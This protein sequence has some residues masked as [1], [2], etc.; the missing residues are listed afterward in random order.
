MLGKYTLIGEIAR[1]G[2][3]IVYLAQAQGPGGFKKSVIIKELKSELSDDENFREMFLEEANLAARLN[4]RNIV[5]TNEVGQD[6]GRYFM[7]MDYLEGCSLHVARKRLQGDDKLGVSLQL[8]VVSEVLAGLHYAHELTDY[9]G[10]PMGVVHRDV[11]P[12]NVFLTYDGQVKL[13]D[14]GVAKVLNRQLETQAGV[15]KGRVAYMAPEQVGG[16]AV[17]RRVDVFAAGVLLREILTNQRLWA[18]LGEID[19]LKKLIGRDIPLFPADADVPEELREICVKAMAPDPNDRFKTAHAMRVQLEQYVLRADPTGSLA[20]LGTHLAKGFETE[21]KRMKD[22]LDGH[23]GSDGSVPNIGLL[24]PG[25]SPD[26]S[27]ASA[28]GSGA[29]SGS[30]ARPAASSNRSAR[31][32]ASGTLVSGDVADID[33]EFDASPAT[34]TAAKRKRAMMIAGAVA[35]IALAAVVV[36]RRGDAGA[37]T[38]ADRAAASSGVA[39]SSPLAIPSAQGAASAN[40]DDTVEVTVRVTP[41]NAQIFL[42]EAPVEGNPFRARFPRNASA[43]HAVRAVANGFVAKTELVKFEANASLSMSLERQPVGFVPGPPVA[44]ADVRASASAQPTTSTPA[45][46]AALVPSSKP[47]STEI[48]ARGGKPPKRDIDP[49]NPY[50]AE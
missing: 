49:K 33:V 12:Q 14:F 11:G 5:Q 45:Q 34:D 16:G 9:D 17:D 39:P 28:P 7:A 30:G 18:G 26:L 15:L 31:T 1:G 35:A 32:P 13:I 40:A 43:T 10:S 29:R 25:S 47:T 42:D 19:T 38:Q 3:G 20:D 50:G 21:R 8:R 36:V 44:R 2:M 22:L 48:N 24:A 27:A 46:T 4:H 37:A 23:L 41:A 6:N